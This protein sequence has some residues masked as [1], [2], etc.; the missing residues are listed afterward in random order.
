MKKNFERLFLFCMGSLLISMMCVST[1]LSTDY[2]KVTN[3]PGVWRISKIEFDNDNDGVIDDIANHTYNVDGNY[4]RRECAKDW[5]KNNIFYYTYDEHGKKIK[6]EK[7]YKRDGIIDTVT[8]YIYDAHGNMNESYEMDQSGVSSDYKTYYTSDA[9]G[10]Y[11]QTRQYRINNGTQGG[12][13]KLFNYYYDVSNYSYDSNNPPIKIEK[14]FHDGPFNDVRYL[15]Y[16]ENGYVIKKEIDQDDDGTIDDTITNTFN[17]EGNWISST[18]VGYSYFISYDNAPQIRIDQTFDN[19][20]WD[21]WENFTVGRNYF[22]NVRSFSKVEFD[23]NNDGLI[24]KVT[25]YRFKSD[26]LFERI[27]YDNDNDGTIDAVEYYSWIKDGGDV[28]NDGRLDLKDFKLVLKVLTSYQNN[29]DL[30][31]DMDGDGK[32]SLK[33][34]LHMIQKI[35]EN[36]GD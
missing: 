18:S 33:D 34:A 5:Y 6:S 13:V 15:T 16:N 25:Y 21:D 30:S 14:G 3:N 24:D 9:Y 29:A 35:Q 22:K 4:L 12:L 28:N 11:S 20:P 19:D 2:N 36:S 10:N 7:D 32:I 27:E 26:G 23:S 1:A 8:Q 31:A 17:S